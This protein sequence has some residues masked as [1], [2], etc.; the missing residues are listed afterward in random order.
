MSTLKVNSVSIE[1]LRDLLTLVP[2]GTIM[3]LGPLPEPNTAPILT[4]A[5]WCFKPDGVDEWVNKQNE[6]VDRL[7]IQLKTILKSLSIKELEK[8]LEDIK[9]TL[10]EH[11]KP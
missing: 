3:H 6:E 8:A 11:E 2:P 10:Q 7:F 9:Q 5:M 1:E 4:I